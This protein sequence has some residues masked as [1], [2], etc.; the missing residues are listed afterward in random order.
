MEDSQAVTRP[1]LFVVAVQ[2][3]VVACE[4]ERSL[5]FT[6]MEGAG[7]PVTVSRTWQVMKGRSAMVGGVLGLRVG[8]AVGGC[9]RWVA[10]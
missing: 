5:S 9:W 6:G 10:S 8:I 2:W 4:G 7:R 1:S 3:A